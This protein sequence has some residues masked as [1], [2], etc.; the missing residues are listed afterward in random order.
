MIPKEAFEF[1]VHNVYA[2]LVTLTQ[3]IFMGGKI[4]ALNDIAGYAEKLAVSQKNTANF[5]AYPAISFN[6]YKDIR[7]SQSRIQV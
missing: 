3:P 5:S 6:A 1:D 4:K 7:F 2:G